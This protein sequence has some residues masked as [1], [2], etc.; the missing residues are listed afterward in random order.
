MVPYSNKPYF[1]KILE[2]VPAAGSNNAFLQSFSKHLYDNLPAKESSIINLST[3][4]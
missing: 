2:N 4:P 3:L 1:D